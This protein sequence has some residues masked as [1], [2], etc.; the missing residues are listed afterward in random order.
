MFTTTMFII[1]F[2]FSIVIGIYFFS[3]LKNQQGNRSAIERES[4]RE[5]EKLR[6]LRDIHLTEPLSEKTRPATLKDIVGQEQGLKALRASLCGTNP[7]HVI[8]YGPPAVGKTA[9]AT[10]ILEEAKNNTYSPFKKEAKFIEIDATTLR[11][12]EMGIA[13]PLIGSVQDPIYK[14]A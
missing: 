4:K 11:F 13:Y 9:A 12:D 14:G 7:Q 6:K 1:Q 3:L 2:F 8:R 10:V 5:L